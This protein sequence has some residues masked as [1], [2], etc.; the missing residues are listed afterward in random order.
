MY[1]DIKTVPGETVLYLSFD[2]DSLDYF[3]HSGY[4]SG[5]PSKKIKEIVVRVAP[6]S[7]L[8]P[9]LRYYPGI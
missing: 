9:Y 1:C 6:P 8:V 5:S 2:A 4:K 3:R 7:L